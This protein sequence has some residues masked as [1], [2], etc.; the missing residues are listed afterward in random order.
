M[1]HPGPPALTPCSLPSSPALALPPALKALA[2]EVIVTFEGT[3]EFGNPFMARRSYL[4]NDLY[5]GY[6]FMPIVCRP[7]GGDTGY[8]INLEL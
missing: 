5:W 4:P 2:A 3:T 1:I 7:M 8:T 6:Q